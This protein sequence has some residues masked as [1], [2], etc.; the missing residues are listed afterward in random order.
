MVILGRSCWRCEC[1]RPLLAR[2]LR[3][4]GFG[5]RFRGPASPHGRVEAQLEN[6]TSARRPAISMRLEEYALDRIGE[7]HLALLAP[8][9]QTCCRCTCLLTVV[10][11]RVS[12]H[13]F[14]VPDSPPFV[15][16]DSSVASAG[17]LRR[18]GGSRLSRP[19]KRCEQSSEA[20][21][22][23]APPA[24]P[25]RTRVCFRVRA[26]VRANSRTHPNAPLAVR[27]RLRRWRS[28]RRAARDGTSLR[29]PCVCRRAARTDRR[30]GETVARRFAS[31]IAASRRDG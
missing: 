31:G 10:A 16:P 19:T 12:P 30:R 11:A 15:A 26:R 4:A 9:L 17:G 28:A 7:V 13:T 20:P 8:R 2:G 29:R 5:R 24:C 23:H 1:C 27:A 22:R 3:R 21:R 14:V 25:A 6:D 18:A